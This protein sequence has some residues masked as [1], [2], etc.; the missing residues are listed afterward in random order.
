MI[1]FDL[2][3]YSDLGFLLKILDIAYF[4]YYLIK[5]IITIALYLIF[6]S[7]ITEYK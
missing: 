6:A 1:T 7:A 4:Q 5:Q 2:I 3:F